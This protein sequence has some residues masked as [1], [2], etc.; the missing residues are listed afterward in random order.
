[1]DGGEAIYPNNYGAANAWTPN[2]LTAAYNYQYA[3]KDPGGYTHNA[4]YVIQLLYDSIEALG[5]DV[6][7]YTRP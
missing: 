7:A 2:L 1:V 4:K 5:G 3:Q 6:S